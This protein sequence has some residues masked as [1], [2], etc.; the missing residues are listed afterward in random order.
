MEQRRKE[1]IHGFGGALVEPTWE[2]V[3]FSRLPSWKHEVIRF[4]P[5]CARPPSRWNFAIEQWFN[6][7]QAV[8]RRKTG[9]FCKITMSF[10]IDGLLA[11]ARIT[12]SSS[13]MMR[14]LKFCTPQVSSFWSLLSALLFFPAEMV[15]EQNYHRR[16][17]ALWSGFF[18]PTC[19][20]FFGR[21]YG[22][23]SSAP[24]DQSKLDMSYMVS[25]TTLCS[26]WHGFHLNAGFVN[27]AQFPCR[28]ANL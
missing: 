28:Y 11:F 23:R 2:R 27:G 19:R 20:P 26:G 3:A 22:L 13:G 18:C 8:A 1:C 14:Y 21:F 4:C 9:K 7:F 15:S 24:F 17:E 25:A 5:Y 6:G 12:A 10:L 16:G